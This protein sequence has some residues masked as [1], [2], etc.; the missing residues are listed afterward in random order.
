MTKACKVFDNFIYA[1]IE[2]R[3]KEL[4]KCS[5]NMEMVDDLL[6]SLIKELKKRRAHKQSS[7]T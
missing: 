4:R 1:N 6:T 2:S 7:S 3:R 5:K